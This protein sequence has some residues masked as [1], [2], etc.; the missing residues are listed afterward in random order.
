MII[1]RPYANPI[2]FLHITFYCAVQNSLQILKKLRGRGRLNFCFG[3]TSK[4]YRKERKAVYQI[5]SFICILSVCKLHY[6]WWSRRH[7]QNWNCPRFHT[8]GCLLENHRHQNRFWSRGMRSR[9][10]GCLWCQFVLL[11]HP[12]YPWRW[13]PL[14]C[15]SAVGRHQNRRASSMC[16]DQVKWHGNGHPQSGH[17]LIWLP[18]SEQG[19]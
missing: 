11:N 17:T 8:K 4:W 18:R 13:S 14:C 1:E 12:R 6:I 3:E 5:F 19:T 15:S 9:F 7:Y 10:P 2:T 16:Y